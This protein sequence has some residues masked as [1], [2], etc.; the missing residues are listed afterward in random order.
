MGHARRILGSLLLASG[1]LVGC[2]DGSSSNNSGSTTTPPPTTTP[3]AAFTVQFESSNIIADL[4]TQL[5]SSGFATQVINRI[6]NTV[7]VPRNIPVTFKDCD[8]ANAFYDPNN[9]SVTF[10]Y[11]LVQALNTR[12]QNFGPDATVGAINFILYHEMGHALVHQ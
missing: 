8:G 6:N 4:A 1:A 9:V 11:N 7:T 5:E 10:G 2:S 12:F 3:T